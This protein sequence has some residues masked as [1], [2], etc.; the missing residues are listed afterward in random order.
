MQLAEFDQTV[1]D[2]VGAVVDVAAAILG[3]EIAG[4]YLYGSAVAGGLRP[5][6]DIDLLVISRRRT[7]ASEKRALVGALG[8]ISNRERRPADWRPVELTVAAS[9][10]ISP[11]HYPARVDFL[12]GEW[13]GDAF[14]GGRFEPEPRTHADLAVLL[15]MA[16]QVALPLIGPP[17]EE[18]I[19]PIP[20]AD[21]QWAMT[22][23][24]DDL[25]G[26][27]GTDTANVLLTLARTWFTLGM[28]GFAP[29]DIAAA[30]AIER[31][32]A[33]DRRPMSKARGV[34]LG[35][36]ADDWTDE[37]DEVQ[38]TA[39]A[40]VEAICRPTGHGGRG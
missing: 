4:M 34:Y 36:A 13:L 29:K 24:I 25:M 33:N 22:D 23:G 37:S 32:S 20:V 5:A 2:Q 21:L 3:S 27:L 11:W 40:L 35:E 26:D 8:P 30:W 18:L 15:A 38:A 17:A 16:L 9:A 7:T 6:S 14:A 19:E 1:R 12:Y 31:L 10:D 28:G 39:R